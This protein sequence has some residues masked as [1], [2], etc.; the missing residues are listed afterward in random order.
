MLYLNIEQAN[1]IRGRHGEYT[2][3]GPVLLTDGNYGLPVGC[4]TDPDLTDVHDF[5]ATLEI[6]D[7][8]VVEP[9][10]PFIIL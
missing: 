5:L 6:K 8:E 7:V 3:L 10:K 9:D 1:Q 2:Y 4:L